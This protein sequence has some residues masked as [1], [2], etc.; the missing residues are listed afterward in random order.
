MT[1]M[2]TKGP[3]QGTAQARRRRAAR[4][5]VV[6][7][8]ALTLAVSWL[9]VVQADGAR[10]DPRVL[11]VVS[12]DAA[13]VSVAAGVAVS[14]PTG[15]VETLVPAPTATRQVIVVRRSRAS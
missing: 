9:G 7:G 8:S 10:S 6:A 13:T 5:T 2:T 12:Q 3:E 4:L 11:A 15:S 1:T 14:P